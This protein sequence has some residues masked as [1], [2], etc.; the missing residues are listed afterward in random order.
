MTESMAV[1]AAC[2]ESRAWLPS[3]TMAALRAGL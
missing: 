3:D 1:N 2:A